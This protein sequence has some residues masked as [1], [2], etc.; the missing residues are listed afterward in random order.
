MKK[1]WSY[2]DAVQYLEDQVLYRKT[3]GAT[4]LSTAPIQRLL[5]ELHNPHKAFKAVYVSGT[6]G[7]GSVAT[8]LAA[9]LRSAGYTTGLVLS[10]HVTAYTERIQLNGKHITQKDF[11]NCV[12]QSKRAVEKVQKKEPNFHASVFEILVAAQFTFFHK[13]KTDIVIVETG[14]GGPKDATTI[15]NAI[16][17]V[18]TTVSLEHQR[19][20]GKTIRAIAR[21]E[22]K[23]L[24]PNALH[25]IGPLSN[26]ATKALSRYV[27]KKAL[28]VGKEIHPV[29][30]NISA[31]GT[32]CDVVVKQE[33]YKNLHT[34]LV[35]TFHAN[36][37]ALAIG[38]VTQLRHKGYKI[39]TAA[40][41]KGIAAARIPDRFE[42]HQKRNNVIILDG[43]HNPEKIRAMVKTFQKVFP[44]RRA[45]VILA[46]KKDKDLTRM[47]EQ[48]FSITNTIITTEI[49]AACYSAEDIATRAVARGFKGRVLTEPNAKKAM[50]LGKQGPLLLVT[51]SLYLYNDVIDYV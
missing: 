22:G 49:S 44:R 18:L 41:Q 32:V 42:I 8:F 10:P 17:D 43:A 46:V 14:L 29:L 21:N 50:R 33:L 20:L 19:F 48:L 24:H 9:I 34:P 27:G 2:Q 51:G 15:A 47:L 31:K 12:Q 35:G 13:H 5:R 45:S 3:L 39:P 28:R 25:V 38:A 36:N 4:R 40:V 6:S 1:P 11:A 23:G 30:R 7:K 26:T 37:I 16:V